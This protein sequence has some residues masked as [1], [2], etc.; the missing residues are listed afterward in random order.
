MFFRF[1]PHELNSSSFELRR[2]TWRVHLPSRPMELLLLLV[3]HHGALVTREEI[4]RSLWPGL[5]VE[6]LDSRINTAIAQIRA[7]LRD[8]AA[9]PR[10]LETVIGKGYRFIHAVETIKG[11]ELASVGS[12]VGAAGVERGGV[13]QGMSAPAG[14]ADQP[15]LDA[16]LQ[17]GGKTEDEEV[18][19]HP[20]R[21]SAGVAEI[22]EDSHPPAARLP[23][24][25]V[26]RSRL[27]IAVALVLIP[28]M[29]A[30]VVWLFRLRIS[31]PAAGQWK[32]EQITNNDSDHAV[33]AAAISPDG[34]WLA[35]TDPVGS[36]LRE[37]HTGRTRPLKGPALSAL[38]LTW[39]KDGKHLLL[40]GFEQ[41]DARPEI[42]ILSALQGEA[43]LFW[44]DA[45]DGSPSP[46]G[47]SIAF[48]T[49][50]GQAIQIAN[51][52]G[53]GERTVARGNADRVFSSLFWP[54]SGKRISYQQ[55]TPSGN[56]GTEPESNYEWSYSSLDL[57][58]L[59]ETT[60]VKDVPFDSAEETSTG[61]LYFLRSHPVKDTEHNGL[62]SV[63]TDP[64][65]GAFKGSPKRLAAIDEQLTN[66]LSIT[67]D[68]KQVAV[69]QQ[70]LQPDIYVA[71]LG[72]ADLEKAGPALKSI[73]RLTSTL[74]SDY[75][76]SW[77]KADD[78]VYYESNR[79]DARYHVF[80]QRFDSPSAEMLTFGE[81]QQ[82]FPT[83]MP[84]GQT[85][86]Y[87]QWAIVNGKKE[88]SIHR[89]N[90]D[91]IGDTLV[92]KEHDLDE[93][94]CP[95]LS[96]SSCVLRETEGQ[97]M[98]VFYALDLK[99][100]KGKELARS[101]WE[102][103]FLGDWALSPDGSTAAIPDHDPK[104]PSIRFVSLDGS[105]E[106]TDVKLR[107]AVL[108][109]EIHWTIDSRGFYVEAQ[110]G[111]RNE[112]QYINLNGE[113]RVLREATG[114]TWGL[115]SKNGKRLAFADSTIMRNVFLWH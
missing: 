94:R 83:M 103:T 46:D 109:S 19:Q 28:I 51:V 38:K 6:D 52:D 11:V 17:R 111:T 97:R 90:A 96:G 36:W 24:P 47:H 64:E 71:E 29:A 77:N 25:A 35:Y 1:G 106:E 41:D 72:V 34:Q 58:S 13:A 56:P 23:L 27:V 102:P 108:L 104:S 44:R 85:L 40:T 8:D 66:G 98:F 39:F 92:W 7:A 75:P 88:R 48:T 15:A 54:R 61:R 55:R 99:T 60:S 73:R 89:A 81:N 95:L 20:D 87:E 76:Y 4:A 3:T 115:P 26:P 42:W 74:S 32:L 69:V 53:T 70:H 78:A 105:G 93:W 63:Q 9:K 50:T 30:A 43:R 10:Y 37:M 12:G 49:D 14:Q 16:P 100:G 21:T 57:R 114:N 101:A 59:L 2:S 5:A 22:V 84:D 91:G 67:G 18:Q 86:L 62:W 107:E 82:F 113:P 65:T 33:G 79:V 110:I 31:S 45:N 80:R 68:G 112:L